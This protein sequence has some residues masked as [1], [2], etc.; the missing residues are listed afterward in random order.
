MKF[1]GVETFLLGD[2]QRGFRRLPVD[3]EAQHQQHILLRAAGFD[4]AATEN[5]D[6]S[7]HQQITVAIALQPDINAEF[8][9]QQHRFVPGFDLGGAVGIVGGAF[10]RERHGF[11]PRGRIAVVHCFYQRLAAFHLRRLA[12]PCQH[13]RRHQ[14]RVCKFHRFLS[15]SPGHTGTGR[16]LYHLLRLLKS[17]SGPGDFPNCPAHGA[18]ASAWGD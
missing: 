14:D 5:G 9:G 12:C 6:V 18:R 15:V 3:V 16:R 8:P 11:V 7:V 10:L 4:F 13:K 1:A 2:R 17:R